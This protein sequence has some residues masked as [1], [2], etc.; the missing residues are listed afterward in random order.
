MNPEQNS[1]SKTGSRYIRRDSKKTISKVVRV[2]TIK[3]NRINSIDDDKAP[4]TNLSQLSKYVLRSVIVKAQEANKENFNKSSGKIT[5]NTT[6]KKEN[7]NHTMFQSNQRLNQI[8]QPRTPLVSTSRNK[9]TGIS[10]INSSRRNVQTPQVNYN[11]K[12]KDYI[13]VNNLTYYIRCPYC[14]HELNQDPKIEKTHYKK[15]CIENKENIN[16]NNE[17][18]NNIK[19]ETD[20]KYGIKRKIKEEKS[21]FRNF[22]I[23]DQGVIVFKQDDRPTTSIQIISNKPYLTKYS[24]ELKVFGKKRNIAIYEPPAPTKKVF[25]RPIKI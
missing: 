4:Q 15:I 23:N 3:N 7:L 14:N 22:Y 25:V 17:L 8:N 1:S 24:S 20:R 2:N 10:V 16:T 12:N 5:V 9:I 11:N 13:K 21:E 18:N 19:F 6:M